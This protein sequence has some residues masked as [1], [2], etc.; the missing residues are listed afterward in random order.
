MTR[1]S[2]KSVPAAGPRS[3]PGVA[4][5]LQVGAYGTKHE[6]ESATL[7]GRLREMWMAGDYGHFAQFL[8]PS[9]SEF[10]ARL[11][12]T[13]GTRVLD[14]ACGAGQ[15]ALMAARAGAVV[16]GVDIAANLIEQARARAVAEGLSVRFD[17][18]DAEILP[19]GNA[20]FDLVVSLIGAMFAPRS[21]LVA[22][23]M[24]RVCRPGGRIAMGNWTPGGFVGR[25]FEIHSRYV[26]PPPGVPA[27]TLWGVES[28]VRERL[29]SSVGDLR[30][31]K[32]V[33]RLRYPFPP[34]QVVEFYRVYYGPT[35]RTFAALGTW[36]QAE[37]RRELERLWS[38]HNLSDDGQTD[39]E[40]EYL[41]MSAVRL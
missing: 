39:V 13:P 25:M 38:S 41:A 6:P 27:P 28:E 14:L 24:A 21:A 9:A 3:G 17:E 4:S 8:T 36:R 34:P 37:L 15:L 33:Y 40:A 7:K 10:F 11:G 23:E 19:Y 26:T 16:T 5:R 30:T 2:S 29:C 22:A 1:L 32:G 31:S 35:D 18:G 12:V 20:A